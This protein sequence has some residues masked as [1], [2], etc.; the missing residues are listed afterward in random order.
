MKL[1]CP[2]CTQILEL[3]LETITALEGASHF[4]CPTCGGA[5]EV[6]TPVLVPAKEAMP[7][8]SKKP[9]SE[10]EFR[11]NS[12]RINPKMFAFALVLVALF[13]IGSLNLFHGMTDKPLDLGNWEV[14]SGE[15]HD[16]EGGGKSSG[17]GR[18]DAVLISEIHGVDFDYQASI[19]VNSN[20]PTGGSLIFR[21][22]N[23]DLKQCYVAN[24]TTEQGGTVKLFKT[25]YKVL[26][27]HHPPIEVGKTYHLRVVAT[28]SDLK[29]YFDHGQKPVIEASD[30]S[31]P[32]GWFGLYSWRGIASYKDVRVNQR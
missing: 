5:V 12:K 22:R 10:I 1:P 26:G 24:I 27:I 19:T 11:S 18:K 21:S 3:D 13:T 23:R 7:G 28:G 16:E 15:W 9:S 32:D 14:L 31:Y 8:K 30:T 25:P 29:V 6:P 2:H 20:V 4:D 17:E